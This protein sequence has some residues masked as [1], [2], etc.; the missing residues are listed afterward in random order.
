MTGEEAW[1]STP[2]TN[3]I[4]NVFLFYTAIALNIITIQALRKTSSLPRTLKTLL[5]S[6][7]AS[8]LAVGL[9]AHPVFIAHL[10]IQIPQNT[11]DNAYDTVFAIFFETLTAALATASLF[12]V[13]AITVDRFLAIH[14]H[15]RYQELVTHKRVIAVV[16]STWVIS[17]FLSL[18]FPAAGLE[19]IPNRVPGIMFAAKDAVCVITT[20]F[21]H[22]KI[23][24]SVRHHTGHIQALQVQEEAQNRE[25][26]NA[27]RLRKTALA[28]L[29][30]YSLFLACYVPIFFVDLA[31]LFCGE[32]ALIQHL[33]DYVFTLMLSNSSLNPLIY[34]W[35][36]RHIRHA[37]IDILR[38]VLPSCH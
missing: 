6:L 19:W 33:W 10:I 25:M 15:L 38:S 16:I 20:G 17:A 2:V 28:T 23:Y 34:S 35:K 21:L 12:S 26:K 5:L 18:V 1:Y 7:A 3:C 32:I 9:L 36:M 30:I 11:G 37:V 24:A 4:L 14:L 22:Y 8:D 27:V 29:Y 13:V 31:Q